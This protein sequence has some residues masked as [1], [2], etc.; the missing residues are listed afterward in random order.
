MHLIHRCQQGFT[1]VT[2]MGVLMVGGMLV[3]ASFAAVD[4]DIGFSQKDDDS[5]QA[6]AAAEAGLSY[7]MNR[8]AQD[9]SYYTHC[10]NVP[11]PTLNAVNNEWNGSGADPRRFRQ[12]PGYPSDYTVELLAVQNPSVAGTELCVENVPSSM[13]DQSSGS[14]RIRATGRARTP[15]NASDRPKKRSIVATLR[16]KAFLDYLYF[17][18]RETL[19]PLAYSSTSDQAW[20]G[21]NC[22]APRQDR[23]NGCEEINFITKDNVNGPFHSNDSI[24]ICGSPNFGNDSGDLIELNQ[25]SPGWVSCG[26]GGTPDFIGT[27]RYPGGV[28]PMPQSNSE[29]EAAADAGYVFS[30]ETTIVLNGTSMNV[31]N[32]GSTVTK[33]LPPSGVVYVKSTSCSTGYARAQTYGSAPGCGNVRVSGTYGKDITIGADNDIIITEDFESSDRDTVLG[34]L[35]ANNFVRVY[36]PVD[37]GWSGCDN[38]GGPGNIQ[39]DAAILALNHSFIVDNWYCGNDLGT[40]TVNGAI[41]QKFRG[42]VG[43]FSGSSGNVASGYEKNYN[44]ND[45]LRFREP[46]YFVNPTDSPWKVIRQNEQVPAR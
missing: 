4:P 34:G 24:L 27:V 16:R 19:D 43:T 2:L 31:T 37:F 22:D 35:I 5:K 39:I 42:P 38:D 17:T 13:I 36:H 41:A 12:I 29:L 26:G 21:A 1:T 6:Y 30:G 9:S 45:T 10:T 20:A 44:Y 25:E 23:P 40:L 14:F 8:L 33:A 32:N 46:P 28:L 11:S 18:D 7:Y 3:A 15:L